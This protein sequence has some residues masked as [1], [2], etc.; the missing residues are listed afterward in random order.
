MIVLICQT[1]GKNRDRMEEGWKRVNE[2]ENKIEAGHSV[3]WEV[4]SESHDVAT[5][6]TNMKMNRAQQ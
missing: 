1:T 3:R 4:C 6:A 5:L 2:E